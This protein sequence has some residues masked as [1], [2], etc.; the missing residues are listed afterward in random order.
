M[1]SYKK[2]ISIA[3]LFLFFVPLVLSGQISNQTVGGWKITAAKENVSK[4]YSRIVN[5]TT[6]QG[7][8]PQSFVST[9]ND[10]SS[11]TF[12]KKYSTPFPDLSKYDGEI[13]VYVKKMTIGKWAHMFISFGDDFGYSSPFIFLLISSDMGF[14]YPFAWNK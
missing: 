2:N 3:I 7:K 9:L 5:D 13:W 11:I 14:F 6:H 4:A 12:E 8:Y 10:N 1:N